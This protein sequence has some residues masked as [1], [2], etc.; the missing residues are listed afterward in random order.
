MSNDPVSCAG[1]GTGL[2]VAPLTTYWSHLSRRVKHIN[3][4]M[5]NC[6]FYSSFWA[7][8]GQR[9]AQAGRRHHPGSEWC[10]PCL[11]GLV[12]QVIPSSPCFE[13]LVHPI[14]SSSSVDTNAV[15]CQFAPCPCAIV[16][17]IALTLTA[18][19]VRSGAA[20]NHPSSTIRDDYYVA[21]W[22]GRREA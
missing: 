10:R 16:Y 14:P 17:A 15:S 19:F 5:A 3:Q 7:G 4:A 13:S 8:L 1:G 9:A 11:V 2:E 21:G 6:R 12:A 20:C 22:L 18:F